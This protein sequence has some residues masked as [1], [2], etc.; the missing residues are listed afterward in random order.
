MDVDGLGDR[1]M[2]ESH[3]ARYSFHS[4]PPRCMII[5]VTFIGGME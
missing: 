3:A 1:I 2:E 4:G 5:C